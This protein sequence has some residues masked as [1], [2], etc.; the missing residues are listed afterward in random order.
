MRQAYDYW[1]DQPGNYCPYLHPG[2]TIHDSHNIRKVAFSFRSSSQLVNDSIVA[3]KPFPYTHYEMC[4]VLWPP[5]PTI[6]APCSP[7]SQ[8]L[9]VFLPVEMDRDQS[10]LRELP[11]HR[12]ILF[13]SRDDE[14]NS[15]E[16]DSQVV[17]VATGL[18]I[19]KQSTAFNI[20]STVK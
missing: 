1:Q 20:A 4:C 6:K 5:K 9:D 16:A 18:A 13:P 11:I 19:S 2:D 15:E 3:L 17:L 10:L 14:N 7:V 12:F 8:V